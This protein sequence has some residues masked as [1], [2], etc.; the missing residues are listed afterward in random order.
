MKLGL[1]LANYS[2]VDNTADFPRKI[3]EIVVG[4][5]EAGFDRLS[6]MDHYFQI[7]QIGPP[8]TEMFEAYNML[9]YIA[10]RTSKLKLG[11]KDDP[12][13][14]QF[15]ELGWLAATL[16]EEH[17]GLGWQ[18]EGFDADELDGTR[19]FLGERAASIYSGSNEIQRNIIAKRVLGLPD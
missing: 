7:P 5:E 12:V 4:A 14:A 11:A 8:E 3:D 9:G 16:P 18:G 19:N 17:G 10:A 6:V 2:F 15:A 13:W 1:H